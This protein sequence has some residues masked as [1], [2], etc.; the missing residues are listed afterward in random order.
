MTTPHALQPVYAT[1]RPNFPITLHRGRIALEDKTRS[2][3]GPGRIRMALSA[4]TR[5]DFRLTAPGAPV[6]PDQWSDEWDAVFLP[7]LEEGLLPIRQAKTEAAIAEERR[8]LYVGVTRAR[9]YLA[10]SWA[11][12]RVGP[13]GKE[14][15]RDRSRFLVALD[16]P[17]RPLRQ[18]VASSEVVATGSDTDVNRRLLEGLQ[19]WRRD[20]ARTDAVPA[21]VIA[22]D[23]TLAAI[24]EARPRSI[25]ALRRVRGMG[26]A[27][28]ERYGDEILAS[29]ARL[30]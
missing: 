22:H 8:L 12:R 6:A 27:K 13:S 17:A 11:Q 24:A 3:R 4:D 7:A 5:I 20:R 28:L 9:R 26:P 14:A 1:P 2:R 18:V 21:Y 15:R 23:A 30:G 25:P 19:L 16:R 10:L 29:V